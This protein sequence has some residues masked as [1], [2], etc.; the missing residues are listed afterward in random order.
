MAFNFGQIRKNNTTEYLNVISVNIQEEQRQISVPSLGGDVTFVD[1]V[2]HAPLSVSKGYFV[3]L[4]I[5]KQATVQKIFIKM[6]DTAAPSKGAQL[7]GEV[8]IPAGESNDYYIFERVFMPSRNY[9]QIRL[10]LERGSI[11]YQLNENRANI[12]GRIIN[13]EVL[14]FAEVKNI[15][16]YR[17][18]RI[19]VQG[20]PGLVMCINGEQIQIG[21]SGLF[22]INIDYTVSYFGVVIEKNSDKVFI[23]D[24]QY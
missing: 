6:E 17:L 24:Y 10:E 13:V 12:Y 14:T 8:E 1:K 21:K 16:P 3:R 11:D 19:G 23:L 4:K 15:I 9:N 22:E 20:T 7:V 5:Y 2:F 18:K